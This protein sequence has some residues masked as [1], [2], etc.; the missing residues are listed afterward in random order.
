M[1]IKKERVLVLD[2][3]SLAS[4][5]IVRSLGSK[6]MEI[7]CGESFRSNL[8]SYSKYVSKK[9][10]Y[11]SPKD[12]PDEFIIDILKIIKKN[13]YDFIVPV[14]D[15][16]T[17]LLAKYK[18]DISKYTNVYLADYEKI[19]K[20]ND[21]GETVKLAR[22]SGVPVPKTYFPEDMDIEEIKKEADYPVL[23]RP[24]IGSGSRGIKYISSE[25]EFDKGYSDVKKRYGT[26]IVQEYVDK[27]GYSTACVLLDEN[28][29]TIGEFS[30]E[31]TK[32]YPISGG[33]TVVGISH[34]DKETKRYAT[35]LLKSVGWKGPAEVE[36]ILD[37]DGNPRL[38]EVNPRFWMPLN[39]AVQ[40]GVDFPLLVYQLSQDDEIELV[41]K[42]KL[43]VKYRWLIPNEFL[44][45]ISEKRKNEEYKE[46]VDFLDDNL[47]YGSISKDDPLPVIGTVIQS[48]NFVFDKDKRKQVLDRGW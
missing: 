27:N 32:E 35:N 37:Q 18:E 11:P 30:Y 21:K 19:K 33:P 15:D 34:D 42:Y 44:W 38:L 17:L 48:L 41:E 4:L 5:S 47:C 20:L 10:I 14:R 2:G 23:I 3:R 16:T 40:S 6:G 31:R 43:G 28:Q 7:H 1:P 36:F 9:I 39:L 45:L 24:R 46:F 29:N 12:S 13:D 26:P 25:N 8:T 22:Q